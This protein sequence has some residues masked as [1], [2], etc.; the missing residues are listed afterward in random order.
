MQ[1]G[2]QVCFNMTLCIVTVL[3]RAEPRKMDL[4]AKEV[5]RIDHPRRASLEP[6]VV[7]ESPTEEKEGEDQ[8]SVRD[9]K[10]SPWGSQNRTCQVKS[11][12]RVQMRR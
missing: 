3:Q 10:T 6:S 7:F 2:I 5:E 11:Q 4:Y 12:F 8:P 1:A 9:T